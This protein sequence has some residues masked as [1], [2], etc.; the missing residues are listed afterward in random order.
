MIKSYLKKDIFSLHGEKKDTVEGKLNFFLEVL[1]QLLSF[2][3]SKSGNEVK[4]L[5]TLFYL[6]ISFL[7]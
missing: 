7:V 4:F 6:I 1:H 3:E 5:Q 2:S